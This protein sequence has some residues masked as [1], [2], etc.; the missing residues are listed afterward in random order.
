MEPDAEDRADLRSVRP[1]EVKAGLALGA[2]GSA[3][4]GGGRL[5]VSEPAPP[6][7]SVWI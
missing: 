1:G 2:S 6:G 5:H 3:E 7:T 4:P